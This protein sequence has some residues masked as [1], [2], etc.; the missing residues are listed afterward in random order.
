MIAKLSDKLES[1][2]EAGDPVHSNQ[3]VGIEAFEL[4][5]EDND[6]GHATVISIHDKWFISFN[7]I[8]NKR[9]SQEYLSAAK[10]FLH[11]AKSSLKEHHLR[12]CV[13]N[14]HSASELAAKA[15]LLGRPDKS[16]I[17]AKSHDVVHRKINSERIRENVDDSHIDAFNKLRNLRASA[18]YL[19]SEFVAESQ[20]IENMLNE[21]EEFIEN[22]GTYSESKL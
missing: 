10:E 5:E 17:E 15:Y 8:Y 22:V 12:A 1:P 2:V 16:I 20:E 13:D 18:R 6:H 21:V 3:L 7:F 19:R 11:A 14:L 9:A 4:D